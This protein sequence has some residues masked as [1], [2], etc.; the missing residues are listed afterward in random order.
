MVAKNT[1]IGGYTSL[2]G[3]EKADKL[4]LQ[5]VEKLVKEE[6]YRNA[7]YTARQLAKDLHT[8]SR[9]ISAVI[10]TRFNTNFSQLVNMYRIRYAAALLEKRSMLGVT[11]D[12]IGYASGFSNK[13]SFYT[14]FKKMKGT[15]PSFYRKQRL[16]K[17][18]QTET[19]KD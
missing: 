6:I 11:V 12:D 18:E 13:Q 3:A 1:V 10:K 19:E 5:I 14:A 2:I 17:N 7:D 8:N 9:Y 15:T 16:K 4:Y